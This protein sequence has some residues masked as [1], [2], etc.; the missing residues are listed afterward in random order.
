[1]EEWLPVV[2]YEGIYSVSSVGNIR[3][4][5]SGRILKTKLNVDG[6]RVLQLSYKNVQK[7]KRVARLVA[8]AF[9]TGKSETNCVV[10]HLDGVKI[11]DTYTN[12]EWVS[13]AENTQRAYDA[14][15]SSGYKHPRGCRSPKAKKYTAVDP[16]GFI[17][18]ITGLKEFCRANKLDYR[19]L[20]N[21]I[22]GKTKQ[23]KGWTKYTEEN[24]IEE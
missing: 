12:L 20:H 6:Y 3:R 24:T 7:D 10:D 5:S 17:V 9:C 1:M 11:N 18:N 13:V 21:V 16:E 22:H 4:E 23:H 8:E 14:G 15:L 2:G 19:T